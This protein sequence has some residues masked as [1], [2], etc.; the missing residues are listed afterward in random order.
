MPKSAMQ[1]FGYGIKTNIAKAYAYLMATYVPG[2]R[3]YVFGFSR[4]AYT[5]RALAGL[6]YRAG[7]MRRGTD[8][9]ISYLVQS[10]MKG[11]DWSGDDGGR[12]ISS[13]RVSLSRRTGN[14]RC[15]SSSWVF[16]TQ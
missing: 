14:S 5:A 9:L 8:N 1:S 2:D 4:G 13:R 10:Y 7:L 12:S 6:T 16:G 3:I 11:D 15:R